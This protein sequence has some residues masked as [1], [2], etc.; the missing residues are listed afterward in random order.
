MR[1]LSF[2]DDCAGVQPHEVGTCA[3]EVK[4]IERYTKELI[5][6]VLVA[7]PTVADLVL[8]AQEQR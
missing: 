1:G 2:S 7:R 6:T 4:E 5:V 8:G 3:G